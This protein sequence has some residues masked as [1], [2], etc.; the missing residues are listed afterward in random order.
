MDTGMSWRKSAQL[1]AMALFSAFAVAASS[2]A[3]LAQAAGD[4]LR[5]GVVSQP[6]GRGNLTTTRAVSPDVYTMSAIY[7]TLTRADQ[8]GLVAPQL[9]ES[10][11]Q[12]DAT[13]WWVKLRPDV[14]FSNGEPLTAA[15][16][17]EFF[18]WM[19]NEG[20]AQARNGAVVFIGNSAYASGKAL[21]TLTMEIKTATPNGILPR[22]LSETYIAP[23]KAWKDMGPDGFAATPIGSGSYKVDAWGAGSIRMSAHARSWR[24]PAIPNLELALLPETAARTQALKA[25]Q[26][27]IAVALPFDSVDDLRKAGVQVL[28]TP[29]TVVMA[30][31]MFQTGRK[32]PFNDVRVRQAVN[33]AV[34]KDRMAA[35]LLR[36]LTVPA[37]QGATRYMEGYNPNV[38]PYPYDP[39][40]AK[41]LLADAG[42]ANGFETAATVLPG[43][44]PMDNEIYQQV[45]AD[46]AA[47]GVRI[48]LQPTPI[49][50]WRTA[51]FGT[52]DKGMTYEG[53]LFQNDFYLTT[54]DAFAGFQTKSCNKQIPFYCDQ[55]EQALM[56]Q[57]EAEADPAKRRALLQDLMKLA[58]ENAQNLYLF[59]VVDMLGAS[60]DV[61]GVVNT[62]QNINYHQI[63]RIR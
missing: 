57:V 5:V 30:W 63:L 59:E 24:A 55:A 62:N 13:T 52:P 56:K 54:A 39:A 45:A 1:G 4:T 7:D 44:M 20:R 14:V 48:R 31:S 60:P 34:N 42:F 33:H 58:A 22:G 51:F 46:L 18:D 16:V 37:G 49:G 10:W 50:A 2:G 41:K 28:I 29:R 21:D 35:E 47:V 15:G 61:T 19:R 36:G 26:L 11:W 53:D 23:P 32:S 40:K 12:V 17:I 43:N 6:P 8:Y 38:K 25:R 3:V 9:A 27:D